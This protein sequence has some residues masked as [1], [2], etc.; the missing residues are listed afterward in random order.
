MAIFAGSNPNNSVVIKTNSA[1]H[2]C[3]VLKKFW[4]VYSNTKKHLKLY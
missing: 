3:N 2:I 4:F 1:H